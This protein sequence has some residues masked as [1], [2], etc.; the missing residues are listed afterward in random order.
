MTSERML[1]ICGCQQLK[2]IMII[3]PSEVIHYVHK[4]DA[5]AVSF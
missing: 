1:S 3:Y 4:T 5:R 2:D